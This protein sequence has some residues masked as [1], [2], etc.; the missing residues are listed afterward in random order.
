MIGYA[1]YTSEGM[2]KLNWRLSCQAY[3]FR[4]FTLEE[5]LRKLNT[6][7]IEHIEI[8]PNQP[9]GE[10]IEG[11]TTYKMDKQ[12]RQQLKEL[13]QKY[14]I[15][16]LS[17]GVVSPEKEEDWKEL[18][19]FAKE[20]NIPVLISEPNYHLLDLV[21]QLADQYKI[22][23]A[24]HNHAAPTKYWDPEIILSKLKG[25]SHNLG[26]CADIGHFVRSGIPAT[27]A[28]NRLRNRIICLHLKDVNQSGIRAA[29]DLPWGKGNCDIP[30][31]LRIIEE[32]GVKSNTF[33]TIEYE[34]NWHNSM[35]EIRES[36]DYLY[37]VT[38]WMTAGY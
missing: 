32:L 28:V 35:P 13:L 33:F 10:G 27:E 11:T 19:E 23:V 8:Y 25:R 6:L 4:E 3:T 15:K 31:V 7:G 16:P 12:K 14:G 37:R 21:E 1:Q 18:F 34:Y 26:V 20:L 24:I 36:I 2:T 22:K 29:H 9:I 30:G 17:Y 5:T 38:H